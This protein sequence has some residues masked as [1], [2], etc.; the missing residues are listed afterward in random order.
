MATDYKS[1]ASDSGYR[2]EA[3][4]TNDRTGMSGQSGDTS[5][6]KRDIGDKATDLANDIL[7]KAKDVGDDIA[8]KANDAGHAIHDA[9][10][11]IARKTK[12]AH[13]VVCDFTKENP[14]AAVL[15]AFGIGAIIARI[16]P[17]R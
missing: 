3:Q 15:I 12:H 7:H 5:V 6:M 17:G 11:N 9:G 13:E 2:T 4:R 8:H 14:T 1:A 16:L 10:Q